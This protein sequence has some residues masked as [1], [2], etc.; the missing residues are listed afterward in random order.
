MTPKKKL[1]EVALPLEAINK[2]AARPGPVP[3][4]FHRIEERGSGFRRMRD[5]MLDHGLNPPILGTDKDFRKLVQLGLVEQ[6]GSGRSTR[7]RLMGL[8]ES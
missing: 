6:V 4:L 2:T 7:Y 8:T 1:I 3:V 5:Q